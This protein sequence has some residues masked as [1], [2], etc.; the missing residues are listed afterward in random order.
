MPQVYDIVYNAM[1]TPSY[2]TKSVVNTNAQ[3]CAINKY[4]VIN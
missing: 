4:R 1:D 3:I 2:L